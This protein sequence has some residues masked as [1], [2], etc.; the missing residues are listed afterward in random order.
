MKSAITSEVVEEVMDATKW[1]QMIALIRE[2]QLATALALFVLWQ[3][4]VLL[5]LYGEVGGAICG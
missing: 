4:G 5:T 3:T 2:N 1:A